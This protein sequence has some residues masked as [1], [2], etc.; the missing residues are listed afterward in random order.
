MQDNESI[1]SEFYCIAF[2]EY[3]LSGKTLLD[4][5]DLL[6]PNDYKKNHK[7]IFKFFKDIYG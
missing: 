5:T 4:C 6:S 1:M 7:I 2:K 3:I